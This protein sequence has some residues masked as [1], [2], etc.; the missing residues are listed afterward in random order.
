[1]I[2]QKD[3]QNVWRTAADYDLGKR[4]KFKVLILELRD[5]FSFLQTLKVKGVRDHLRVYQEATQNAPLAPYQN[6][7]KNVTL[8]CP[9]AGS[10]MAREA[11]A[12][13]NPTSDPL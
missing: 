13:E 2:R 7:S 12:S 9:L 1:M 4:Y 5:H 11:S 3:G 8:K 10:I 6:V